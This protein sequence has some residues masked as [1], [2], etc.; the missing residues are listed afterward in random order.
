MRT[1]KLSTLWLIIAIAITTISGCSSSNVSNQLE[2]DKTPST[3]TAET[4][5]SNPSMAKLRANSPEP[6]YTGKT[7][8][9]TLYTSDTQ[10]QKLIPTEVAIPADK[11]VNAAIAQIIKQQDSGDFNLS[12][13]RVSIKDGTATIDL[14]V[15]PKSRRQIVSLSS[16]E[17]FALFGSLRK[18][19]TSNPNWNIKRVRFTQLGEDIV[20]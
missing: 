11:P 7:I 15:D 2:G 5:P 19:L 4:S 16:C 12:G 14:R 10:C 8:N 3:S 9:A 18:T 6:G 13:Y 17:Q 1:N 20:L